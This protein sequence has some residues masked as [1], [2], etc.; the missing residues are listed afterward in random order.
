MSAYALEVSRTINAP[1][2]DVW[3]VLTDLANA[4]QVLSGVTKIEL[5]SDGPYGVGTRWRETR[6][7]MG[8]EAT[9]EMWVVEANEPTVTV[10]NAESG[11]ARYRTEFTLT[12]QG[13]AT[14]LAMNFSAELLDPSTIQRVM[15][16]LFGR[17]GLSMTK[18]VV[19]ADLADI[20]VA[21]EARAA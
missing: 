18:K 2:E 15:Q 10:V 7:M 17:L 20:A 4:E 13:D 21:A 14:V 5:L 19:A 12:E 6:K 3:A 16:T 9:E 11:G 8:K 1:A